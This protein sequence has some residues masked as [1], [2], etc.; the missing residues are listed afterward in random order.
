MT[1]QKKQLKF[2]A[3]GKQATQLNEVISSPVPVSKD[4]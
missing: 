1:G 3:D 2:K 4:Q